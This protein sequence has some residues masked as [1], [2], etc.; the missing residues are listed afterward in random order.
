MKTCPRTE[1]KTKTR[2]TA[3]HGATVLTL[4]ALTW[5]STS[6]PA[7]AV[8]PTSEEF[9]ESRR[10]AATCFGKG[11]DAKTVEV[12]FSFI[13]GGESSRE[14]LAGWTPTHEVSQPDRARTEHTLTWTDAD[15]GFEVRCLAIQYRDFPALE[16]T[17]YFKNGGWADTPILEDVHALDMRLTR[18]G[19][20][21]FVVHHAKGSD[22]SYSDYA[23]ASDTVPSSGDFVLHS[24]GW[25]TSTGS[26]S[27][28]PSVEA[29]PMFNVEWDQQGV[30]AAMGWTGPWT[31][32]FQRETTNVLAVRAGMDRVHL[33]LRPGEQIRSPRVLVLFWKG[34]RARGHN[35]WRRLILAHYSP[36]P[37]GKPF[38]GLICDTNWGSWM[39]ADRHIAE[40]EWW[41]DHDLP[42][43]CYWMDAGWTDM[44]KGWV[45]HQSQQVPSKALFPDGLRPISDAAH[46]RGMKFL[47]WFVPESV[48]PGVGI[49]AEHP[50]WLLKPFSY[51]PAFGE[52]V[53]YG[54][55][56]GDPQVNRF[57]IGHFSK[58]IADYGVDVFRQDGL[59][60]WP[61][62]T[63]PDR[64]GINQ[65]RY[66]EGFY[67]FWD[68]LLE[69]NPNL[70]I[71][72]CGCG[73]RKLDLET[74][75]RS[76]VLWRSDSQA[77][78]GFDPI[79]TQC[80]NQGLF[81]WIPLSG[82][83]V[84][85]A[86]LS[87]YSFRSAYC[88]AM[89]LCWPMAGISD[90]ENDRWSQVDI[91]LLRRLLNEYFK[92]RPYVFGD[93]YALTPYSLDQNTWIAWQF[94]RPDLGEGM[95]QAFRRPESSD[96][97]L[98]CILRGLDPN[99]TYRTAD[100]DTNAASEVS[101]VELMGKGL[102][103]TISD[104][105]GAALVLYRKIN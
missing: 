9:A 79:S 4:L 31:A 64:S 43:E 42:M 99:A 15:S 57:M 84:P 88:P 10:F 97:A 25:P 1:Q 41:G 89:V 66:T 5:T 86:R 22:A 69:N 36:R 63:G 82:G 52:M 87:P 81:P 38:G 47:L 102:R 34:D 92:V 16:W 98:T 59:S 29:L 96:G 3:F 44:S 62:D 19:A 67:A 33:V 91:D 85:M 23:P 72:N 56:H 14:L 13:F 75:R 24:H 17:V 101:G 46:R 90:L 80:F 49:A 68:G 77:S 54:L 105:P 83:A 45:A 37:G 103:L 50:E 12:P 71:D 53:F 20:D 6:A 94:D 2:R 40:I 48:H 32:S 65:I 76:V 27:G 39:T 104:K 7:Y 73:G 95:V 58:I 70:L 11:A 100:V 61:E 28:S 74:I 18:S 26:P 35:L 30:I 51:A 21:D 8:T 60:L 78:G 93:Y 55:D